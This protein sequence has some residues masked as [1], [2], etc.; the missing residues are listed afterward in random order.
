MKS[1]LITLLLLIVTTCDTPK[2]VVIVRAKITSEKATTLF[3]IRHAEKQNDNSYDPDLTETGIKRANNYLDYFKNIHFDAVYS[4]DFKRTMNTAKP[5]ATKN[6][7]KI[8]VYNPNNIN[9][10]EIVKEHKNVL[11]V[12]HS[13]T[14][15][16]LVNKVIGKMFYSQILDN[17]Y[18]DVY[19]VILQEDGQI[20]DSLIKYDKVVVEE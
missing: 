1:L 14:T 17:N 19:K 10:E 15:P 4:T 13:N 7:V 9:F 2:E 3:F 8:I 11:I 16:N 20:V 12:G 18:S 5:I 6:N